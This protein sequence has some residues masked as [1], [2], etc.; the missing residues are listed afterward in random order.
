MLETNDVI[1]KMS[2]SL[3]KKNKIFINISSSDDILAF[4]KSFNVNRPK[5]RGSK[6][7]QMRHI[8]PYS[9]ITRGQLHFFKGLKIRKKLSTSQQK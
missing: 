8:T 7:V 4:I 2:Y 3:M 9:F 1:N 6:K 5:V